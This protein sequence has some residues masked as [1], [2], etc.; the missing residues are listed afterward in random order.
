MLKRL[1]NLS[2]YLFFNT[3]FEVIYFAIGYLNSCFSGPSHIGVF[4]DIPVISLTLNTDNMGF[5]I[6]IRFRI[7]L[8]SSQFIVGVTVPILTIKLIAIFKFS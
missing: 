5:S 3:S 2:P 7:L 8:L 1:N 4:Y 6:C